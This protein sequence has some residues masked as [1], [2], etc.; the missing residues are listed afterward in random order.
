ME[1][2]IPIVLFICVT[3]VLVLRPL[4]KNVGRL[5]E[6]MARDRSQSG[7]SDAEAAA[8]RMAVENLGKRLELM[9]DRLDFTERLLSSSRT[10]STMPAP[11]GEDRTRLVR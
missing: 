6:Q 1:F 7:V 4:S 9:E 5:L 8:L 11:L 2:M 10:H 3:A